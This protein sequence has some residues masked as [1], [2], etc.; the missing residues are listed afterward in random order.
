VGTNVDA[1]I[2]KE[3]K[4]NNIHPFIAYIKRRQ[5]KKES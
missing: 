5:K 3:N 2:E 1:A 4:S